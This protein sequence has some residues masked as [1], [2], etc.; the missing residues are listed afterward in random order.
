MKKI[1]KRRKKKKHTKTKNKKSKVGTRE[2]TMAKNQIKK[3]EKNQDT[4]CFMLI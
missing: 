2:S 3:H 4:I 1:K